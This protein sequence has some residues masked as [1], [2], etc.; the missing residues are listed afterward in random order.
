MKKG[1]SAAK[2]PASEKPKATVVKATK[3]AKMAHRPKGQ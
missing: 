3:P 2:K 1:K